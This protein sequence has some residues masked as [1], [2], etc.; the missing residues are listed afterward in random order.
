MP[1]V[2]DVTRAFSKPGVCVASCMVGTLHRVAAIITLVL[3]RRFGAFVRER[4][5]DP[6]LF[7]YSCDS[8]PVTVRQRAQTSTALWRVVRS[9]KDSRH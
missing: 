7:Q 6:L 5:H 8:T 4:E 1:S 9:R 2:V 3:K